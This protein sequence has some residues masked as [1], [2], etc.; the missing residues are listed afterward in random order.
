MTPLS[1]PGHSTSRLFQI[2]RRSQRQLVRVYG[3]AG[4]GTRSSPLAFNETSSRTPASRQGRRA[5]AWPL[6]PHPRPSAPLT[7]PE[8]PY[9][10]SAALALVPLVTCISHVSGPASR[11]FSVT[12]LNLHVALLAA[13]RGGVLIVDSTRK[14]KRVPVRPQP[15]PHGGAASQHGRRGRPAGG[16]PQ[17]L[18]PRP[19]ALPGTEVPRP[20]SRLRRWGVCSV[21]RGV[22]RG[23][24]G[25]RARLRRRAWGA[26]R[27]RVSKPLR[28]LCAAGRL[29]QDYPHLGRGPQ[30]RRG[31]PPSRARGRWAARAS[32]TCL[33]SRSWQPGAQPPRR[34][35]RC[36][37]RKGAAPRRG[38]TGALCGRRCGRGGAG[39]RRA[40]SGR[41]LAQ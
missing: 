18:Y 10:P 26:P 24:R 11:S 40:G 1:R 23:Q 15:Q 19:A 38:P 13:E 2:H 34:R 27:R 33:H 7:P 32:R 4:S 5:A 29:L 3:Q 14:G 21:R 8:P 28:W 36:C 22:V 17:G 41:G 37:A 16:S 12:R 30:P 35:R 6:A 39:S 25:Q 20:S 31:A 9:Q